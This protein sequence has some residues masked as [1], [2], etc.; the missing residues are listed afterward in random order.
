MIIKASQRAGGRNLIRH[1]SNHA[2]NDHVEFGKAQGFFYQSIH[3]CLLEV[4]AVAQGTKCKQPYFSVSFNPPEGQNV[5]NEQFY[6]AFNRL[7]KKLGLVGQPRFPVFHEKNG[8]RHAHCVWSRIDIDRMKAIN[9]A[10]FKEKAT[11]LSKE[12]F[13]ENNSWE[14]PA[15]LIDKTE[16]DPF[17][18]FLGEFR[19]LL[20]QGIDPMEIKQSCQDAWH[21]SVS[22]HGFEQALE[23][24]G[25]FLA[26]G[27]KRGFVVIDQNRKVYSLSRYGGIKTK[28][29]K[30]RLGSPNKLLTVTKT[31]NYIRS[32]FNADIRNRISVLKQHHTEGL[33]PLLEKKDQL[34]SIQRAERRE[35]E[36]HQRVKRHITATASKDWGRR[37]ESG[38]F[39]KTSNCK[40]RVRFID[41]KGI[42]KLKRKHKEGRQLMIFRHNSARS[43][44]QKS[45]NAVRDS[46]YLERLALA[47]QVYEFR[48]MEDRQDGLSG[49]R[50]LKQ[51][52][53]RLGSSQPAD[54][55]SNL[56]QTG[57]SERKKSE[58][59]RELDR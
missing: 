45:I 33:S 34:V 52:F 59:I 49:S 6:D 15:G 12:L 20:K 38:Q 48:Q 26:Q 50:A 5:T 11:Q 10:F 51:E 9:M 1:L 35:L 23:E 3:S 40:K 55:F 41:R 44:L 19:Q 53:D 27:D 2:D 39:E 30:A 18:V 32:M 24:R 21:Y 4:E 43:E 22:S 7:E 36:D 17:D 16:K 46:H 29:L 28:D 56:D 25:L 14:T 42:D 54:K 37:G 31:K 57:L 58:R 47:K 8:R 13:L